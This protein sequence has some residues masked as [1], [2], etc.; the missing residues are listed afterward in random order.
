MRLGPY[1]TEC[2]APGWP[3][4]SPASSCA[5]RSAWHLARLQRSS[6][7]AAAAHPVFEIIMSP[8]DAARTAR[9]TGPLATI[10]LGLVTA[11][12]HGTLGAVGI[13]SRPQWV[14]GVVLGL[15]I[16]G[17]GNHLRIFGRR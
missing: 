2:L 14:S 8:V 3:G 6:P 10:A 15:M 7:R 12:A 13:M 1:C 5:R 9:R 11:A 4:L 17:V 16:A